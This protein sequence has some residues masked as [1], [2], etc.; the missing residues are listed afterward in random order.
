MN[1]YAF[2]N[3]FGIQGFNIA[4]YGIIIACGMVLGVLL[5]MYRAKQRGFKPDMILD[6]ML[7]AIP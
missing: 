4:W 3:L 2:E 1:R 7:W 6:F 5:A